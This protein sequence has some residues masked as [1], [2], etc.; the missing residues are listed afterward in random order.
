MKTSR[1][2]RVV[3]LVAYLFMVGMN[4]AATA[5][6]LNGQSTN[7][8]SDRYDTLFAPIGFTFAIWGVIYLLLGVYSVYQLGKDS[9]MIRVI[10]PWFIASSVLNGVWIIAWHYEVLW[11]SVVIIVG[12]LVTLIRINRVTTSKRLGWGASSAVVLPFAVYFGWVSVAT[13]ANVSATLVQQGWRGG[14]LFDEQG[15]TIAILIV[16]AAIG[17]VAML[18]TSSP[19]YGLVFVWAFWGIYSRHLASDEWDRAY[20]A[21]IQTL[22]V[23]L[24]LLAVAVLVSAIRW[25]RRTPE[26]M[27]VG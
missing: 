3:A 2:P 26:L 12:L 18:V 13:V 9:E 10:T 4:V 15:W 21:I 1:V 11:L 20:P 24:P 17:V 5:L 23:A 27:P 7:E 8:I 19:A 16:A 22:Q 14:W 25:F 6:P